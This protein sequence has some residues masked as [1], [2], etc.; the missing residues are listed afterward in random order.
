MLDPQ[1]RYMQLGE[2]IAN[3]PD[4]VTRPLPD[5]SLQW[6]GRLKAL[7]HNAHDLAGCASLDMAMTQL[8]TRG[9]VGLRSEAAQKI[10]AAAFTALAAAELRAS[11]DL[12]GGNSVYA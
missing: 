3:F 1:A 6:F 2:L 7:L 10:K 11:G 12:S 8:L 5:A 9:H 4:L